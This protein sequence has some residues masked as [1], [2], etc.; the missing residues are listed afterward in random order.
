MMN[1]DEERSDCLHNCLDCHNEENNR[2][3]NDIKSN[4]KSMSDLKTSTLPSITDKQNNMIYFTKSILECAEFGKLPILYRYSNVDTD[5]IES[6][7]AGTVRLMPAS[8]LNDAMEGFIER[9]HGD[10]NDQIIK[11]QDQIYLKCFTP[12]PYHPLMWA[13]YGDNYRGICIGYNFNL[14]SNNISEE[15][16]EKKIEILHH[17]YPIQYS[18]KRFVSTTVKEALLHKFFYLR[19]SKDWRYE[20]EWRLIYEKGELENEEGFLQLDFISEIYLGTRV[21]ETI[22][23]TVQDIAAKRGLPV[24]Q[25]KISKKSGYDIVKKEDED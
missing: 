21:D 10:M 18:K 17:L 24:Y 6:L 7:L 3:Y 9:T 13:H 4:I 8:A 14:N 12:C 5:Y 11:W 25:T 23:K 19:K 22:K 15:Q 20:R 2:R 16:K 1:C